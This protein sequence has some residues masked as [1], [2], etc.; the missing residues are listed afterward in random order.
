M[1][2]AICLLVIYL[3]FQI[4]WTNGI[5]FAIS[6][7]MTMSAML[8]LCMQLVDRFFVRAKIKHRIKISSLPPLPPMPK[9][10]NAAPDISSPSDKNQDS[11]IRR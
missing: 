4:P 1:P 2:E 3:G 5:F 8:Y 10:E 6:V 9:D 7:I 11:T